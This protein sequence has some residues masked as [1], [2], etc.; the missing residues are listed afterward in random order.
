MPLH[1]WTNDTGWVGF[2]LLWI[3]HLFHDIKPRLPEGFRA[4]LGSVPALTLAVGSERP[5]VAVRHWL[6]EP[7]PLAANVPQGNGDAAVEEPDVETATIVLDPQLA[8]YV[9]YQGR[10]A[11]AVE[12]ISP[13]N[14]DR[15][16]ARAY[17]LARYL[18]YLKDGAH[19]LLV[20][21]HRRPLSFSF[22]DALAQE[23]QIAQPATPAPLAVAYRVGEP[24]ATG[25]R[26]LA[27]WRRPLAVG[28]PLPTM[29]LPLTVHAALP[30]PL[31]DAYM[32]AA[33]DAYLA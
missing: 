15:P 19:L 28:S 4:Y 25:G 32:R 6:S 23:L 22:A 33:A 31:V 5:D 18:G 9:T 17:Y 27:I 21:V 29:P 11:A 24:A 20:D 12:L 3:T 16:S 7:P 1:D 10:L 14:K 2:H 30:V 26:L 13:R 8:L